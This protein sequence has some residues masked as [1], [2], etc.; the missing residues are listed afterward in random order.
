RSSR[1]RSAVASSITKAG[2]GDEHR[3]HARRSDGPRC[4]ARRAARAGARLARRAR[5]ARLLAA[6]AAVPPAAP[7]VQRPL[8]LLVPMAPQLV[9]EAARLRVHEHAHPAAL[10]VLQPLPTLARG[11]L[12]APVRE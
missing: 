7:P 12:P 3:S 4:P 11:A 1:S 5:R 9:A 8:H 2:R 10:A 6:P